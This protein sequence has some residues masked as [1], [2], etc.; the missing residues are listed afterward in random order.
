MD[1]RKSLSHAS[2]AVSAADIL[3]EAATTFRDRNA[4]YGDNFKHVGEVM[5]GL[6]PEGLKVETAHDWNRLHILL[7]C[8]VKQTR[9]TFNWSKGG[10]HDSIRDNTVYSAMLEMIDANGPEK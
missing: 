8:V 5:M 4:V 2:A 3:E 10:H 9:Y 7:L 6:F 1:N